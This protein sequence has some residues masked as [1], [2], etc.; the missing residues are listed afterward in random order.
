MMLLAMCLGLVFACHELGVPSP[1][2]QSS[3]RSKVMLYMCIAGRDINMLPAKGGLIVSK[4]WI[5]NSHATKKRL[6]A[7]K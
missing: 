1:T 5:A 7:K 4:E 2:H 6:P 3:I